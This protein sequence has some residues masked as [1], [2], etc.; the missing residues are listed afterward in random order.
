MDNYQYFD[1][2]KPSIKKRTALI[3]SM[4]WPN[5]NMPSIQIGVLK[6]YI[7]NSGHQC[8]G[9]HWFLDIYNHIGHDL[10]DM[11]SSQELLGEVVYSYLYYS[12]N[13]DQVLKSNEFLRDIINENPSFFDQLETKHLEILSRYD[14]KSIDLVGF[15]LNFSQTLPSIY[16]AKKIKE[17]NPSIKIVFGGAEATSELGGS[18]L[19]EFDHVDFACNGEGEQLMV[20]LLNSDMNAINSVSSI[21]NLIYRNNTKVVINKVSQLDKME[22]L[23]T[24]DFQEYFKGVEINRLDVFELGVILPIESSRGC[25]YKCSF[26]SLNIQWTNTRTQAPE[27][28][29]ENINTLSRKYKI[30]DFFFVD[31]IT[32]LNSDKIFSLLHK[33]N[34]DLSFFYEMRANISFESLKLMRGTGLRRVQIGVEAMSSSLLKKFNKKST[35]IHNIQGL[36]NCEELG[37]NVISNFIINHPSTDEKDIQETIDNIKFCF[38]LPPPSTF[39]EFSLMYGAPD[40]ELPNKSIKIIG[41]HQ[42]YLKVYPKKTYDKLNLPNKEYRSSKKLASWK[43]VFEIVDEWKSIYDSKSQALLKMYDGLTFLKIEDRRYETFDI[44]ILDELEREL[45]LFLH[46]IKQFSKIQNK[47]NQIPQKQL[48]ILLKEFV[49]QKLIFEED[50]KYLSLAIRSNVSSSQLI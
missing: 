9:A 4:P 43:G 38:H 13:R 37:I 34:M 28:V 27:K 36:K 18:L 49:D 29:L 23:P 7:E 6:S 41:N 48:R 42:D 15:T 20:D 50:N 45:Y 44:Y 19:E 26:C 16:I 31:N 25:Y 11:I 5:F 21:S 35:T 14:W 12:G 46:Q 33:Q 30:L 1:N 47:F 2:D 3:A 40:F 32:P 8:I 17:L 24:P 39:S 10:Y 22:F